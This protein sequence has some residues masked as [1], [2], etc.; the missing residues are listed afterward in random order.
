MTMKKST[1]FFFL[2][3]SFHGRLIATETERPI[4]VQN[5]HGVGYIEN[6]G[7]V[8]QHFHGL[9]PQAPQNPA[10]AEENQR[11]FAED[12]MRNGILEKRN[13]LLYVVATVFIGCVSVYYKFFYNQETEYFNVPEQD[14]CVTDLYQ[15]KTLPYFNFLQDCFKNFSLCALTGLSGFGRKEAAI[16]FA[17]YTKNLYDFIYWID[18]STK[19]QCAASFEKVFVPDQNAL[20]ILDGDES[21]SIAQ[22]SRQTHGKKPHILITTSITKGL[23]P[24]QT[25]D[26]PG[27]SLNSSIQL[28][29]CMLE[30]TLNVDDFP[31]YKKEVHL[32]PFILRIIVDYFLKNNRCK[33]YETKDF[34]NYTQ[35]DPS[36]QNLRLLSD[37]QRRKLTW[38]VELILKEICDKRL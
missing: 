4:R 22:K 26:F 35:T 38:N 11:P 10:P 19:N 15:N 29:S 1:L 34:L 24:K 3:T 27:L 2:L 31:E 18:C 8:H 16:A 21:Q 32:P 13:F 36:M 33:P 37:K 20:V 5:T 14:F 7:P 30:K 28:L 17:A 23:F 12:V 9:Q 25:L 6:H